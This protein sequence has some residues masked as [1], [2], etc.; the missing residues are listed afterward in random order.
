MLPAHLGIKGHTLLRLFSLYFWMFYPPE[1]WKLPGVRWAEGVAGDSYAA[2]HLAPCAL[3]H[4]R[5]L[6]LL[7]FICQVCL[8]DKWGEVQD[9]GVFSVPLCWNVLLSSLLLESCLY[10]LLNRSLSLVSREEWEFFTCAL[11]LLQVLHCDP[12]NSGSC[13]FC[14]CFLSCMFSQHSLI[15]SSSSPSCTV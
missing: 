6:V 14:H 10:T 8:R 11:E 7:P 9:G 2:E 3:A 15:S 4:Q 12:K 5:H 1:V 13:G